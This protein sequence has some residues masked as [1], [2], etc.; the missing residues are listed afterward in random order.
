MWKAIE[1][2]AENGFKKFSFGRTEPENNGLLQ[3]KRGWGAKEKKLNYYKYD[4][5]QDSF[6]SEKPGTKSSYNI[7]KMMPLPLLKFTG[8]ILYRHVG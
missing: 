3:F 5:K 1:W 4:L 7:F 6:V 2:L 8:N